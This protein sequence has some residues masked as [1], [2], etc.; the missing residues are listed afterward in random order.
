VGV[1]VSLLKLMRAGFAALAV[2]LYAG[3]AAAV[4]VDAAST[5]RRSS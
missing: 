4:H 5:L 2:L 3:V 1:A